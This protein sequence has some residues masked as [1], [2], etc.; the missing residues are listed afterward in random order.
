MARSLALR[1]A[2]LS[3]T[4]SALMLFACGRSSLDGGEAFGTGGDGFAGAPTTGGSFN[5]ETGGASTGGSSS[6]GSSTGG[7]ATGGIDMGGAPSGGRSSGGAATGGTSTGGTSTGGVS[8]GGTSSGGAATGGTSTG[9]TS[10]GG[11]ATGGTGGSAICG[12]GVLEK[13]EDCDAGAAN[14]DVYALAL[15]VNGAD[16]PLTPLERTQTGIQFFARSSGSSHTGFEALGAARLM[17]ERDTNSG[18]LSLVIVAGIDKNGTGLSQPQ[19]NV[20]M[21]LSGVP[22]TASV[23]LSDEGG[24]FAATSPGIVM[25]D[26]SFKNNSDG[27]VLSG[28]GLPGTWTITIAPTFSSGI[29]SF[30]FVDGDGSLI[31]LPMNASIQLVAKVLPASC[32]TDCSVPVCGDGVLDAGEACDDG[33]AS[34]GDGCAADCASL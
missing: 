15:R 21:K 2:S 22:Q 33:N 1:P 31:T 18:V 24:E 20:T 23:V 17:L 7:A 26:W 27:G 4:L 10:S 11:A 6:G 5:D 14:A 30:A 9:G 19:A 8:T 25:G 16:I 13:G 12:N 34:D 3:V 32:R 28:L 29:T